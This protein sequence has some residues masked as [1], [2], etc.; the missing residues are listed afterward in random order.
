MTS[1][2]APTSPQP[3]P[4]LVIGA[5][6][7]GLS[8]ALV[9]QRTHPSQ[10]ITLL[11]ASL[12]DTPSP[13]ASYAS[14]WAGAHYRPIPVP[15]SPSSSS[16]SSSPPSPSPRQL[17]TEA[18]LAQHTAAVMTHIATTTPV[19]DAGVA[20]MPAAEYLESPPA[21]NLALRSGDVY[22]GADDGFRVLGAD[23]VGA[24][25]VRWG[26]EYR[27]YCVN[28]H[29][30]LA[31]LMARFVRQGG[32][33]EQVSLACAAAAFF[34]HADDAD[35]DAAA[36]DVLVVNCSG[37]NFGRDAKMRAVRGQT[38]LV[39][40][41]YG[42]TVTRQC[43]DGTWAFLIPRPGPGGGTVVGGTKEWDDLEAR[44]RAETRTRLLE[45]AVR[46]FP[47][48]VA[49]VDGFEALADN[50]G[51]RPWR[52]GGVRIEVEDV[53]VKGRTR[54]VVHG[55]GAGGRGYELSW[56]VAERVVELVS[57]CLEE[58]GAGSKTKL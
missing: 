46:C 27:S 49:A 48:F 52:E 57:R 39:R 58:D 47:D 21:E 23:E 42:R 30:Y 44:P 54:R 12:P 28:V 24:A 43:A 56:G 53:L 20:T 6:V 14:K 16:S 37:A 41:G 8:T 3:K 18:A 38:V 9:L 11:A 22:A 25:G 32:R 26:C 51:W 40:N 15:S 13:P 10:T 50:V 36:A 35:D 45:A 55:Y 19:R 17:T 34:R 7:L 31:W 33:V 1:T 2:D 5:G 4:I 29:V